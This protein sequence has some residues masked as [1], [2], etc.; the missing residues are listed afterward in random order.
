MYEWDNDRAEDAVFAISTDFVF[1]HLP[2]TQDG[3]IGF[4]SD[5]STFAFDKSTPAHDLWE[6][7]TR[8]VSK[9]NPDF[10]VIANFYFGN[11]QANGSDTRLIERIGGDARLIYKKL[12]LVGSL[13][14][15]D[16][17]P[18]DYHRDYNITFPVQYTI[19]LSTSLGKPDW[20]I[21]PNTKIGIMGTWRSLNQY[22]GSRYLPNQTAS[23]YATQPILSPVGFPNGSEWEIRTYIHI[24]IGK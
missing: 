10:G 11:A 20:F 19:D 1:R 2:T 24:N 6:S 3:T 5:R 4:F 16:W 23:Q 15:N 13:K 9:M 18:Y 14:F 8:I 17:G 22:S 21:L 12:K 7:N